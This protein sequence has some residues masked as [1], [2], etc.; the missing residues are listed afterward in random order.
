MICIIAHITHANH[1][2]LLPKYIYQ[3]ACIDNERQF[4]TAKRLVTPMS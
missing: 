2:F 3:E 4:K 1:H